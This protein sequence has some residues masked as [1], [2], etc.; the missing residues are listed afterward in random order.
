MPHHYCLWTLDKIIAAHIYV[1]NG[2]AQ[3]VEAGVSSSTLHATTPVHDLLQHRSEVELTAMLMSLYALI[4]PPARRGQVAWL[5]PW[6]PLAASDHDIRHHRAGREHARH[7]LAAVG[8]HGI[9]LD[10]IMDKLVVTGA[11]LLI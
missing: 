6:L 11:K 4:R 9:G 3:G 2:W 10:E 8:E 7:V 1:N 5:G